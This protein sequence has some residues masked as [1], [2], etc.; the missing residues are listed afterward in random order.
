MGLKNPGLKHFGTE[1]SWT[2][3][4]GTEN[5]WTEN[6]GT[7]ASRTETGQTEKAGLKRS[8][9]TRVQAKVVHGTPLIFGKLDPKVKY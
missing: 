3:K 4:F 2:E 1:T 9:L 5:V 7:E 8:D 6:F